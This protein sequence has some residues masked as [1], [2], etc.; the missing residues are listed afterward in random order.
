L[1]QNFIDEFGVGF[2]S[3]FMVATKVELLTRRAGE[4]EGTRWESTGEG[5]YVIETVSHDWTDPLET[6][7]MKGEGVFEYE[8]LLFVPSRAPFD[9]HMRDGK[10]GVQLYVKRVLIMDD[11]EAL[12]PNHLRFI[13][14]VVDPH[15]L[16]LNIS[17]EILQHDRQIQVVR[18]RLVKKVLSTVK[19]MLANDVEKYRT[20]WKEFG[21]A[22]KEGF[23]EDS[24]NQD[25][26]LGV[27]SVAS[28]N[29]A[30]E[31]TTPAQ[32]VERMKE[33][34]ANP[35]TGAR[36]G[37]YRFVDAQYRRRMRHSAARRSSADPC[38]LKA[39]T[40]HPHSG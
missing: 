24:E 26:L 2:Y 8:A 40:F 28:T 31:L 12:M 35:E 4:A 36:S 17:G 7:H 18:W 39:G 25:A 29:D 13:K 15:D 38:Q 33:D 37:G 23:L 34:R 3:T 10:R 14:G 20:F 30:T 9:L 11:C 32:Y 6:I 21:Q 1:T 19:D 16:S 5:T 27:L 22:V